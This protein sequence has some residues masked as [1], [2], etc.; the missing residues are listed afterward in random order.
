MGST[1]GLLTLG[2]TRLGSNAGKW[3]AGVIGAWLATTHAAQCS[4]INPLPSGAD[5]SVDDEEQML[6]STDDGTWA[7]SQWCVLMPLAASCMQIAK[8]PRHAV[9]VPWRRNL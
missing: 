8:M 5:E 9:S 7:C 4:C 6:P 1:L 3:M 2:R